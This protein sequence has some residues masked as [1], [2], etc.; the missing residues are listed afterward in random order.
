MDLEL[1]MV[2]LL[3]PDMELTLLLLLVLSLNWR[4]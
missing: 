2:D 4:R 3:N 1:L